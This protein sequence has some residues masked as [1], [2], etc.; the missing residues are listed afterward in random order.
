MS[1]SILKSLPKNITVIA[2]SK[3]QP[4]AKIREL[5]RETGHLDFGENYLQEASQKMIELK[6]LPLRW[7]FIGRLQKNKIKGIVGNFELIHSVDSESLI[8]KISEVARQKNLTQKIL[9]QVNLAKED[10]KGGFEPRE[11]E[12]NFSKWVQTPSIKILGLMTMPPLENSKPSSKTEPAQNYFSQLRQLAEQLGVS[13][14]SMGTSADYKEAL[15][16]GAT[17]IRLGT[18]LFGERKK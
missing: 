8:Q 7:H 1:E 9:L 2:V 6:D 10:S 16:E 13:E 3:L 11:L 12:A 5:H 14:L 17:M 15:R 18:I 4:I